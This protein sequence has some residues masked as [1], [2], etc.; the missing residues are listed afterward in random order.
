MTEHTGARSGVPPR[1]SL[2]GAAPARYSTLTAVV[3]IGLLACVMRLVM[4][5]ADFPP[6]SASVSEYGDM[7][8]CLQ[9][10]R[11]AV[12]HG[13]WEFRRTS[14][15]LGSAFHSLLVYLVASA[16]GLSGAAVAAVSAA[17]FLALWIAAARRWATR[18]PRADL[19]I[20][21]SLLAAHHVLFAYS[22]SWKQEMLMLSCSMLGILALDRPGRSGVVASAFLLS[23]AFLTKFSSAGAA[24]AAVAS[25]LLDRQPIADR[26]RAVALW[27]GIFLVLP[28]AAVGAAWAGF[29]AAAWKNLSE[30][31]AAIVADRVGSGWA[32]DQRLFNLFRMNL[33]VRS[34]PEMLVGLGIFLP[35]LGSKRI[36]RV[37]R[38]LV[39]LAVIHLAGV[40][41]APYYPMR[42]ALPAAAAAIFLAVEAPS[43]GAW[44][45]RPGGWI[46]GLICGQVA[47]FL[48]WRRGVEDLGALLAVAA[49]TA[50]VLG[51]AASRLRI[52]P[53]TARR[54]S[55]AVL[56]L[57]LA[58]HA[59]IA[60]R[61]IA[62]RRFDQADASR[63]VRALAVEPGSVR[64]LSFI[65]W[66]VLWPT[67]LPI[68]EEGRSARYVIWDSTVP[69][70]FW[71]PPVGAERVGSWRLVLPEL[72]VVLYR[73]PP[74]GM[75]V[76]AR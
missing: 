74:P 69:G 40:L 42:W 13:D 31:Q 7:G 21:L 6:I 44:Q 71:V 3:A 20:G 12:Q 75:P 67:D 68:D 28:L 49:C 39:L 24:V 27:I 23:L 11:S 48:L 43:L 45:P 64:P 38:A 51:A 22:Y 65:G 62:G 4:L 73:V 50:L 72:D 35:A 29:D 53:A 61:W 34:L 19:F 30:W 54:L 59:S 60:A 56:V 57:A 8:Y 37:H 10:V 2:F 46:L 17:S 33:V 18:L 15:S 26:I 16:S 55:L 52:V 5:G 47:G 36:T 9:N 32:L 25:L 58:L 76:G 63:G 14:V 66:Q 1:R 41:L 70:G